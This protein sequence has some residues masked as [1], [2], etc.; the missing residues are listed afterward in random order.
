MRRISIVIALVTMFLVSTSAAQPTSTAPIPNLIRYSG[1][2][3]ETWVAAPSSTVGVTFAI[4]KHQD[5][6]A[7]IWQEMQNVTPEANGNYTV[8]LGSATA[9]G[10]PDDL[11]SEPEQR[12]LGVQVQGEAEQ[13]RVMLVSV[14]Y[15][16]K[17]HE[18]ETLGGL[19]A[20]AFVKSPLLDA[21]QSASRETSTGV[22]PAAVA[23]TSGYI[24]IWLSG[25]SFINSTMYQTSAGNVG[26]GTTTP[27][28]KLDVNGGINTATTYQVGG[29]SV[30]SIGSASDANLFLGVGAGVS[31]VA[32]QGQTNTFSGNSAGYYNTTGYGNS[33]F[34]WRAG[35]YNTSGNYNTF[36]GWRAGY[37][38]T[39]GRLNTFYGTDAG[40]SNTTGYSNTF[41]GQ[42]AGWK[43]TSGSGN[44]FYGN[45]AGESNITGYGNT[46]SG[47]N[48]GYWNTTGSYNAFY[49]YGAGYN[50]NTGTSNLYIAAPGVGAENNTIRI[51][52]Q[53]NGRAQQN[54]A[55]IAG[56]YGSSV[57]ESGIGVY[58][59]SNGQLGTVVSSRRFKEQIRDMGE[60][61]SA[62]MELRPVTFLYKPEYDKGQRT[63]QF[64]LI[65]EE[66][67]EV[68]PEL[69]AYEQDGKPFTVKYHYLTTMLLNEMQKQYHR[70]EAEAVVITQQEEKIEGLQ[71]QNEEFQH[72]LLRLE[73]SVSTLENASV[74]VEAS[75]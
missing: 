36:Y 4:Y 40:Y 72:R 25:T 53:G 71:K 1:T 62:L 66:V 42:D 24:P 60:S 46:F 49:G 63:L 45:S 67:A 51:G 35:Y 38:N 73:R 5:G 37:Y 8:I 15:A 54:A 70:A 16:F 41:S 13:S 57:G 74:A 12:W 64:G 58:V 31:N 29:S 22:N 23:A 19:A 52:S 39:T 9:T 27:S 3:K 34:G 10:L 44:T 7:P 18:A 75:R 43:T 61:S 50:N 26:V 20:S 32:G 59:D 56:I 14:P 21:D 6:G 55:Y 2:L 47:Y 68:Y 11:F 28:A 65:A 48:A 69:V 17:A 30:L 33:F